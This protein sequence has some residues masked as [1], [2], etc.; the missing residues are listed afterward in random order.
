MQKCAMDVLLLLLLYKFFCSSVERIKTVDS[1]IPLRI[2][3]KFARFHN[4]ETLGFVKVLSEK[5]RSQPDEAI[6]VQVGTFWHIN[7]DF[8]ALLKYFLRYSLKTKTTGLAHVQSGSGCELKTT[9]FFK[10]V[11]IVLPLTVKYL[12]SRYSRPFQ[13]F[14][15]LL[16]VRCHQ[17][18]PGNE[19]PVRSKGIH[20]S[21]AISTI[22]ISRVWQSVNVITEKV[23]RLHTCISSNGR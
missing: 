17:G 15:S 11:R 18:G 7:R 19:N 10:L 4:E 14:P 8:L 12:K 16:S 6:L 23:F 21:G 5:L 13:A 22:K 1:H 2:F 9:I 3:I 20:I